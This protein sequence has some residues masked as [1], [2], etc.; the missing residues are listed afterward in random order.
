[1]DHYNYDDNDDKLRQN[2]TA[3][4]PNNDSN[5][6]NERNNF[7]SSNSF[8]NDYNSFNNGMKNNNL[9]YQNPPNVYA[10]LSLIFGVLSIF[11]VLTVWGSMFAGIA[12][13]V[14]AIVSKINS[15]KGTP[16]NGR[17]VAGLTMGIIFLLISILFIVAFIC[18]LQNPDLMQ[19]YQNIYEQLEEQQNVIM[20]WY[21][22]FF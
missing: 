5:F 19:Q 22:N 4:E 21:G 11:L 9:R 17:A 12:A 6:N 2:Q 20:I 13:I 16:M 18:I 7:N 10:T 1:M 3:Q 15:S 14:L 8:N